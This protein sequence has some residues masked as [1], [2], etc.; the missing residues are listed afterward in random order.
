MKGEP[1]GGGSFEE[2]GGWEAEAVAAWEGGARR[3]P[4]PAGLGCELE[5][6][7]LGLGFMS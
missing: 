7:S 1:W 5:V 4:V 3:S 2:A 6:N